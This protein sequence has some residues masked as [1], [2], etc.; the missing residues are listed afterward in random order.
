MKRFF[1]SVIL[2][3]MF[4]SMGL[5]VYAEDA[6]ESIQASDIMEWMRENFSSEQKEVA[7]KLLKNSDEVL[8]FVKEK[9][10]SGEIKTEEDIE[11]ALEEGEEKFDISLT[12]E[13]KDK[14]L[15]GVQKAK[16]MGVDPEQLL[17]Q[18]QDICGQMVSE[19]TENAKEAVK[20]SVKNS[21]SGFFKD[22][23]SRIKGFLANVFS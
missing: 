5:T 21:L 15:E 11:N 14:I 6:S 17:D 18:A 20:E 22:M 19:A 13:E 7:Y 10:E 3:V 16:E 12:Q 4:F 2:L 9:M 8:D 23:G 1:M